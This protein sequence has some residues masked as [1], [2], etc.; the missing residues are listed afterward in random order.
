MLSKTTVTMAVWMAL[1]GL[2][3]IVHAEG[4][5]VQSA[6][7][8]AA[9]GAIKGVQQEMNSG[10]L[11]KGAKEVTKSMIQGAADAAPLVTSQI[12]NQANVNKKAIGKVAR[13]VSTEAVAGAF[14][15]TV[16]EVDEALGQKGDGP[17]ATALVAMTERMMAAAVRGIVA[18]GRMDPATAEKL[19]AAAVRGATSE[20]HF[21]VWPLVLAFF[22]GG[23]STFLFGFGLMLLY[24]LFQRKRAPE[25][26]AATAIQTRPV[27]SIA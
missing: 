14:G 7:K 20:M 26:E 13:Q 19:T 1:L 25:V 24:L 23:L 12:A 11:V 4:G 16:R 6:S 2:T 22:L 27:T 3:G 10:E 9:K 5:I 15:A 8:D 17:L 21:S 18:E